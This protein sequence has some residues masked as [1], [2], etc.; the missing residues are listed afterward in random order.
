MKGI[1]KIPEIINFTFY[2][3]NNE[4]MKFRIPEIIGNRIIYHDVIE[5]NGEVII[6]QHT[7]SEASLDEIKSLA[8]LGI[9][10]YNIKGKL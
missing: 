7:E 10:I 3:S 5:Q 4:T 8:I 2:P 6:I 1:A 9:M